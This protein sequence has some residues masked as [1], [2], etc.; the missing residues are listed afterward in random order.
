MLS[1]NQLRIADS[2]NIPSGNV[3]MIKKCLCLI[4]KTWSFTGDYNHRQ[5][6]WKKF[7]FWEE[8]W[9]LSYDSM[10]FWHYSELC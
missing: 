5:K 9:A 8:D 7:S 1:E 4:M 10:K 3:S 6:N 2:Y